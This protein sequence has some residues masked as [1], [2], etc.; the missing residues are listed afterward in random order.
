MKFCF[1]LNYV[2][3]YLL[4]LLAGWVTYDKRDRIRHDLD[5][6]AFCYE[7]GHFNW[8]A[9]TFVLSFFIL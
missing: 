9:Y 8:F 2:V 6:F 1:D 4:L 7:I 3:A 5:Y